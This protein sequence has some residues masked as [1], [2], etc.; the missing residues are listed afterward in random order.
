MPTNNSPRLSEGKAVR[1]VVVT[2]LSGAGK[3]A[4][5]R[6]LEDLGYLCVD[7]LPA[8]LIPTLANLA[9][10]QGSLYDAVAVV[11]DVRDRLFFDQFTNVFDSLKSRRELSTW[12]I[13]L[14][15]SDAAL[16][17]RF[18][19]TRRP[20]PLAPTG[21]VIE[22]ILAER[23]RLTKIKDMADR[24]LDTS[25]FTVHELRSAFGELFE[26]RDNNRSLTVT[27]L[28]FGYKYGLPPELDL[29]FDFRCLPN[30]RFVTELE[31]LTGHH[32]AVRDYVLKA[33]TTPPFV[34]MTTDWLRFAIPK[35]Q[36][37]GKSYLTIGVGC[38]GGRHRSVAIAEYLKDQLTD[39]TGVFWRV[40]H[41]DVSLQV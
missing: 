36:K 38:T 26:G 13:F 37:E 15:A 12:L 21:S 14:E 18:S 11:V 16:V 3:S 24:V 30:P 2:G 29:L 28:S 10:G 32:A 39:I 8:V 19:E 6:A 41:R 4:A 1:F 31:D 27:L 25:N 40:K 22:G 35:Y 20:H 17:R 5:I 7:N 34:A 23:R 33:E 9:A